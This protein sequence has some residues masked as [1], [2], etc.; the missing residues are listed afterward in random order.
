MCSPAGTL[1]TRRPLALVEC[2]EWCLSSIDAGDL[3]VLAMVLLG[4]VEEG[5]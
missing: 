5:N 4:I 3:V 2:R 1:R